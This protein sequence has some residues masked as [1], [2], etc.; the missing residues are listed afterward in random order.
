MI[1]STQK[2]PTADVLRKALDAHIAALPAIDPQRIASNCAEDG[3]VEDPIG[4][5]VLRGRAAVAAYFSR[6]LG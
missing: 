2:G 1:V 6:G 4:T 5:G 3:E